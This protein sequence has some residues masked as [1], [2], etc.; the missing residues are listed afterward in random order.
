MTE[1]ERILVLLKK[2]K[3]KQAKESNKSA[4]ANALQSIIEDLQDDSDVKNEIR[5]T[6]GQLLKL[7]KLDLL[8][9]VIK[10]IRNL[11][12][13][14]PPYPTEMK[15]SNVK[16]LV[17]RLIPK[18]VSVSNIK[19][20]PQTVVDLSNLEKSISDLNSV[21]KANTGKVLTANLDEAQMARLL[22]NIILPQPPPASPSFKTSGG[23]ATRALVD[24][25]GNVQ[26]ISGLSLPKYDYVSLALTDADT[27]TYT[28]KTGGS[29]GTTVATVVIN[30]TDSTKTTIVNVTK[31]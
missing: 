3:E 8:D 27:E 1:K 15:I 9:D 18:S 4:K 14:V 24:N 21:I 26:T 29:G 31:T 5:L 23:S 11:K 2:L 20:I 28:F 22:S 12:L 13:T 7:Q 10:E 6:R 16:D 25:D 17:D 19:D 30:Y